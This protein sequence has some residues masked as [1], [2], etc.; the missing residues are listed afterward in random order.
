VDVETA[1]R[2]YTSE[3]AYLGFEEHDRGTIEAGKHADLAILSVDPTGVP[4]DSL[5]DVT[6]D[7]TVVGGELVWTREGVSFP[8]STHD[9]EGDRP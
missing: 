8:G 2:A 7:A 5:R 3:A 4:T 9:T 6:V 1:L